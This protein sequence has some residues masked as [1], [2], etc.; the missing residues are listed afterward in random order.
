M[1]NEPSS[2][3]TKVERETL[4]NAV[5]GTHLIEIRNDV[6]E[7]QYSLEA[8]RSQVGDAIRNLA[9][10][11]LITLSQGTWGAAETRVISIGEVMERLS[12]G[13]AWDP[14]QSDLIIIEATEKG[15]SLAM[16]L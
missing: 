9:E 7:P 5:E 10:A 6:P 15:R 2:S 12:D 13:T 1:I 14:E 8:Y 11:G 16:S 4:W 3:L